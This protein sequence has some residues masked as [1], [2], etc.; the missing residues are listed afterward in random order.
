ME[1][2]EATEALRDFREAVIA[3]MRPLADTLSDSAKLA[4]LG[5]IIGGIVALGDYGEDISAPQ[6]IDMVM[7]NM[8]LGNAEAVAMFSPEGKTVQ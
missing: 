2:I 5:H 4:V 8:E 7:R 6:V 1:K 3:A